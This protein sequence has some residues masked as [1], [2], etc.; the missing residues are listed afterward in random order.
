[1]LH[2]TVFKGKGANGEWKKF[3]TYAHRVFYY[4]I[5]ISW[6]EQSNL[7]SLEQERKG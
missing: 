2:I 1:M 5:G 7:H 4:G 3:N 6:N